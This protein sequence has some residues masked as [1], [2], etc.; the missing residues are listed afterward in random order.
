MCNWYSISCGCRQAPIGDANDR[1]L[2]PILPLL[3]NIQSATHQVQYCL[4]QSDL[5]CTSFYT[6]HHQEVYKKIGIEDV[7]Y[8]P[9]AVNPRSHP[10]RTHMNLWS[11]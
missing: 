11:K 8:N 6:P 5:V 4:H 3:Q 9:I 2:H 1:C 10:T 7:S